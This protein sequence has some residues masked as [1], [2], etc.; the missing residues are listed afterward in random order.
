MAFQG[1]RRTVAGIN[2]HDH[3]ELNVLIKEES[4][5]IK[6]F[7]VLGKELGEAGKY[8][9]AWGKLEYDDFVD[10]TDKLSILFDEHTKF[11]ATLADRYNDYR[12]TLK[13]VRAKE[14]DLYTQKQR[15]RHTQEK[16]KAE[17]KK[18]RPAES[19]R[20]EL[21]T[22][23]K[24]YTESC[25]AHE[26]FKRAQFQKALHCQFD[27]WME[28]AQKV[29]IFATFGKYLADQIPQG[30]L[31]AGQ[32]LPHYTG[33]ETTKKI[34]TDFLKTLK[35]STKP[36][37]SPQPPGTPLTGSIRSASPEE[38]GRQNSE[39]SIR[40][41]SVDSAAHYT[42]VD[43]QG[44][45]D[46]QYDRRQS[47]PS[48]GV[49][50]SPGQGRRY[51]QAVLPGQGGAGAERGGSGTYPTMGYASST[52]STLPFVNNYATMGSG[53]DV[54]GVGPNGYQVQPGN[55]YSAPGGVPGY[56]DQ[57]QGG[58]QQH[59][60]IQHSHS[61]P[62]LSV[63]GP[64]ATPQVRP[65]YTYDPSGPVTNG[66]YYGSPPGQGYQQQP[67]GAGYGGGTGAYGGGS[68]PGGGRTSGGGGGGE[69]LLCP[70]C[71]GTVR[72]VD[73]D[74]HLESNCREFVV[75]RGSGGGGGGGSTPYGGVSDDELRARLNGLRTS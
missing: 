21:A 64:M 28:Y 67:N 1:L 69:T 20:S 9:L 74:R 3:K 26:G 12:T 16:L 5:V 73:N 30:T 8:M 32:E 6:E 11:I 35:E 71:E 51:V 66:P 10:I 40:H 22:V 62:H 18:G 24:E 63:P 44:Y 48:G 56:Y 50:Q 59:P 39:R 58:Q 17:I 2:A 31:T 68:Y 14:D 70:L 65:A 52:Y 61:N 46:P 25:A 19:L 4:D 29:T 38:L 13:T 37:P 54:G 47:S 43:P 23:E 15:V 57:A 72:K 33:T 36:A 60:G 27:A 75:G 49:G 45:V 53:S 41:P 34:V 7:K 42:T 55:R